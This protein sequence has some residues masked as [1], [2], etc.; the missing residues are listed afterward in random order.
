M[1]GTEA[2]GTRDQAVVGGVDSHADII[3]VAVV[4]NRGGQGKA[5]FTGSWTVG[6]AGRRR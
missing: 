1:T 6:Q 2:A 3:H 4:T 5:D